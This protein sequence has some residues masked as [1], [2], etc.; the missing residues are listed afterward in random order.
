[1]KLADR[2]AELPEVQREALLLRYCE[3]WSVGAIAERLGRT[4]PSVASLL[5]RGLAE[6]REL[7]QAERE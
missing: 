1:L 4:R 6:L 7:L 5:R 3:G 2:L